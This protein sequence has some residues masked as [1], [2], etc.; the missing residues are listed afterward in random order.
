KIDDNKMTCLP[1]IFAAGDAELGAS[2]V[3]SAI[4]SG[5]QAAEGV[6]QYLM[7]ERTL[8]LNESNNR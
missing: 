7:S 8:K 6:H 1:G 2:L 4:F 5:R 3:V